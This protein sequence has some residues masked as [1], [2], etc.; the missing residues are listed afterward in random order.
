[1]VDPVASDDIL[2]PLTYN[3]TPESFIVSEAVKEYTA[4]LDKE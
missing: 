2:E 1:M 3:W 4:S